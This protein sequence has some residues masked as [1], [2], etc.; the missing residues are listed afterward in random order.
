MSIS[1][2]RTVLVTCLLAAVAGRPE[3]SRGQYPNIELDLPKHAVARRAALVERVEPG[4]KRTFA[5]L[6]GPGCIRHI[7]VV[8]TRTDL[9]NRD[10]IIRLYFDGE[11]TPAVEA[12]L[13]DFFGAM[14]GKA[15]S[16]FGP[17]RATVV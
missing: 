17:K 3:T 14:H 8:G 4:T 1:V 12:P 13:G 9:E 16:R 2:G 5:D 10:I 6:E 11:E 7:W 15:C